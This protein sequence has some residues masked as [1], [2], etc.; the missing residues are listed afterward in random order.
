M[1][2]EIQTSVPSVMTNKTHPGCKRSFRGYPLDGEGDDTGVIYM[3]CIAH[4]V[5]SS[6]S[7][8]GSIAKKSE[9]AISKKIRTVIEKFMVPDEKITELLVLNRQEKFFKII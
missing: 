7:P 8:W 5:K 6:A 2:I 1:I 4:K 9:S 3:A